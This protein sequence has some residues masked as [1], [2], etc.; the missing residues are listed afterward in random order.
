MRTEHETGVIMVFIVFCLGIVL[1]FTWII[2]LI[3]VLKSDF[4]NH[5][6]KVIWLLMLIFLAPLGTVLYQMFGK[7]QKA[8]YLI[9]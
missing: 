2:S 4:S 1:F 6:N 3:D 9:R 8:R 7:G 5:S